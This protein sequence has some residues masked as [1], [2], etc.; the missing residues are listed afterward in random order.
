MVAHD[1]AHAPFLLAVLVRCR[2]FF[3]EDP[4]IVLF[5][6]YSSS[7]CPFASPP[8]YGEGGRGREARQ[9]GE[10]KGGEFSLFLRPR[11]LP[12]NKLLFPFLVTVFPFFSSAVFS[13]L[14]APCFSV[15]EVLTHTS[16]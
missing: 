6:C 16:A 1:V 10:D 3:Q 13:C 4:L 5:Q 12:H 2:T 11:L 9:G 15:L 7:P 14:S 8:G